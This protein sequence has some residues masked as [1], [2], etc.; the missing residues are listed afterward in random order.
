MVENI[1]Y[2]QVLF[3]ELKEIG[4]RVALDDFGTGFSSL[5]YLKDFDFQTLKKSIAVL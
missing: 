4:V 5:S 2:A 3:A 1:E